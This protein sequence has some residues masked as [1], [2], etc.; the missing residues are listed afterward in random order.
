MNTLKRTIDLGISA[1]ELWTFI[2]TPQNLNVLTPPDL[3]F[4]IVSNPPERMHNGL[5]I[6][7]KI[8]L[9]MLGNQRWVTEIKHI[10]EGVSFVDEQRYGPYKL[11]YHF[12]EITPLAQNRTRMTDRVHYHL[13][14]GPLGLV[15][16]QLWVKG[17]LDEIFAY[18]AKK[19]ASMFPDS[20]A[21][22]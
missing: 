2:A 13:P 1:E 16:E 12:H 4:E 8:G 10:N 5:I 22:F 6:E 21:R 3:K 14:F 17:K 19:L 9:P 7:Y 18:R 20:E 15:V 11:W